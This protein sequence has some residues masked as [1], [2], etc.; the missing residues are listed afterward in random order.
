MSNCVPSRIEAAYK[1]EITLGQE[2]TVHTEISGEGLFN[3]RLVRESDGVEV[4][5]LRIEWRKQSLE[6]R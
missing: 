6:N 2:I 3:H 1:G 5:R 4:A